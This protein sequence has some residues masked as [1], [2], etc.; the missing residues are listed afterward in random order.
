M[1]DLIVHPGHHGRGRRTTFGFVTEDYPKL[2]AVQN[3]ISG[4]CAI[5]AAVAVA[6]SGVLTVVEVA[7]RTF[8]RTPLGWNIGFSERYLMV[9]VASLFGKIPGSMQKVL[10][11]LAEVTVALAFLLLLIA[12]AETTLFSISIDERVPP[13][14]WPT[15]PGPAGPGG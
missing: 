8:L 3:A 4:V 9:A 12:G 2:H 7:M 1:T 11:L 10:M 13:R 14:A 15:S 6:I 5:I